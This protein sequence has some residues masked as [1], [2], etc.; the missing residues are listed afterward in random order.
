MLIERPIS[1]PG[2]FSIAG[3]DARDT[4]VIERTEREARVRD[5]VQVAAN[6]WESAGWY[7]HARGENSADRSRLMA[8]VEPDFDARF[9]WL[10]PPILN[11]K[12]RLAM[13]A[14]AKAGRIIAQGFETNGPATASLDLT[15]QQAG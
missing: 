10:Q 12:T 6:H 1:T 8:A 3:I 13:V 4:A 11:D 14:D 9:A 5:G 2:I 15:W 7:G